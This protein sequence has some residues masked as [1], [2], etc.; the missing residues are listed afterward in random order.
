MSTTMALAPR[1]AMSRMR[2]GKGGAT[3][4]VLAVVAFAVS[5]LLTLTVVGGTWMFVSRMNDQPQAVLEALQMPPEYFQS[6][7]TMY[8]VL[9]A[10]ACALL[11][12]PVLGLGAA[13]ARLGARG[14]SR[15]LAALRLIGMTGSQ[16]VRL[17]I[18]E[19]A[20]QAVVGS[21]IGL[22]LWLLTL[23]LWTAMSF[24][25]VRIGAGEML[26]PW[27]LVALAVLVLLLLAVLSTIVGLRR[28]RISPLGVAAN[29]VPPRLKAWRLVLI[30]VVVGIFALLANSFLDIIESSELIGYGLLFG[31][32]MLVIGALNLVGPWVLQLIARP[33]A[34]TSS[35]PRLL[36]ARRIV[37]DPRAAWRN[38]SGVALLA[39]IATFA[40][41]QP[42]GMS[43]EFASDRILMADTQAG[44]TITLAVGLV[45]AATSTL[46]NQA[47][48]V[49]DRAEESVALDRAGTPRGVFAAIRRHQVLV[50]LVVT[51]AISVAVGALLASP[52]FS[53]SESSASGPMVL[54][55][56]IVLGL[57]LSLAAAEA[58]RP[59]QR[60]VLR[61]QVRR[62][63]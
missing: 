56:T 9:A 49:V 15:R 50:P 43:S 29:Q 22:G 55:G 37:D 27:W 7:L 31:M 24:Q 59:L 25:G 61:E 51:L 14:R 38:V 12:V 44:V 52:F 34:A 26:A 4:D 6:Q 19:T 2:G 8:V 21:L 63:D 48:T 45:V 13:A 11:V 41:I 62:N 57:V 36:A 42:T 5:S 32:M 53:V 16:V 17:S 35:V 3:L 39:M 58:C 33:L 1:L 20:V 46:I 30:L 18:V 23:P 40:T 60:R 54:G 10:I 47:S 28:V